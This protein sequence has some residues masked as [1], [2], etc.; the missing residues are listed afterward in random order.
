[1]HLAIYSCRRHYHH[2]LPPERTCFPDNVDFLSFDSKVLIT[3]ARARSIFASSIRS[4]AHLI[5]S[6]QSC[7]SCSILPWEQAWGTKDRTFFLTSRPIESQNF[8]SKCR[9]QVV[10]PHI[11]HL[12]CS[13]LLI[14]S[15]YQAEL[16]TSDGRSCVMRASSG[17]WK[18]AHS[19]FI[20][21]RPT[22]FGSKMEP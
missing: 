16:W 5:W 14:A 17:S 22:V 1:M 3:F 10:H 15:S 21:E 20:S 12:S 7:K 18:K 4:S 13:S 2:D 9:W 8:T 6:T 19:R 11:P